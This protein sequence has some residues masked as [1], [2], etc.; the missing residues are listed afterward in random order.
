MLDYFIANSSNQDIVQHATSAKTALES[1]IT[2]NY[3]Q[4][5]AS[6]ATGLSIYSPPRRNWGIE[7]A[8]LN[9]PWAEDT[10]WDDMLVT[11]FE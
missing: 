8:Y 5:N 1:M 10:V 3:V 11:L 7:N 2:S 9:A 6:S 4:G